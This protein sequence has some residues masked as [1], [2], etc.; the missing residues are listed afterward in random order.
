[1]NS[2][3]TPIGPAYGQAP[4]GRRTADAEEQSSE[5]RRTLGRPSIG[6]PRNRTHTHTH[7]HTHKQGSEDANKSVER[8]HGGKRSASGGE[9]K[10]LN[11]RTNRPSIRGRTPERKSGGWAEQTGP[12]HLGRRSA[13]ATKGWTGSAPEWQNSRGDSAERQSGGVAENWSDRGLGQSRTGA[14]E[15]RSTRELEQPW[16][17][18]RAAEEAN[19]K[20]QSDGHARSP[21]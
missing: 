20:R 21:K 2:S 19:T 4:A 11:G 16:R 1:M 14:A 18:D 15:D 9:A 12:K 17:G 3:S 5:R 13:E 8:Y 10:S 7:T 6:A